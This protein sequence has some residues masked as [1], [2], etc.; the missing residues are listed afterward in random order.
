MC[1]PR[2][3]RTSF[4]V[5]LGLLLITSLLKAQ[6]GSQLSFPPTWVPSEH[7]RIGGIPLT[8]VTTICCGAALA[9]GSA[10]DAAPV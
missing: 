1:R 8:H 9:G 7:S 6:S 2:R 5:A 10:G 4:G 3:L